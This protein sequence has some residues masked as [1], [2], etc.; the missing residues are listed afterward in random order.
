MRVEVAAG[1]IWREMENEVVILNVDTGVYYGISGA[2][3][4]IWLELVEHGLL[5][6]A[7]ASLQKKFEAEPDELQ[8]DLES[9]VGQL[10]SKRI[11]RVISGI[12]RP[13]QKEVES[14]SYLPGLSS[15]E[16]YWRLAD[17][18]TAL[19][20]IVRRSSGCSRLS[21]TVES[22]ASESGLAVPS[23]SVTRD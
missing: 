20:S 23:R 18:L 6:K 7:H 4:H 1:A 12:R 11:V 21:H 17:D 5:E 22:T 3:R 16:R 14:A 10:V 15:H 19:P 13:F 8:R 2:G 9:I